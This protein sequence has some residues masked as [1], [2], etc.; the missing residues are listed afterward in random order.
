M[1]DMKSV[2]LVLDDVR[3]TCADMAAKRAPQSDVFASLHAVVLVARHATPESA[4]DFAIAEAR[5]AYWKAVASVELNRYDVDKH[6]I[7]RDDAALRLR[8]LGAEP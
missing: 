5:A 7:D 4:R 1:S 8:A 2:D 3:T 6:R